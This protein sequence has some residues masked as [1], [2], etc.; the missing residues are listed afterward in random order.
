MIPL[1]WCPPKVGAN[2]QTD[3]R[4]DTATEWYG[5]SG[6]VP[7]TGTIDKILL[8]MRTGDLVGTSPTFR[9]AIETS[10]WASNYQVPSGTD[11]ATN[12][13]AT[14]TVAADTINEYALTANASVTVG[15]WIGITIRHS[16][17][18]INGSNYIDIATWNAFSQ[19]RTG[20]YSPL[21]V[22]YTG[23]YAPSTN[24]P[25]I[26][27]L[28]DDGTPVFPMP[29]ISDY[30]TYNGR[31]ANYEYGNR[32]RLDRHAL[33]KGAIMDL[34][35]INLGSVG[36][37]MTISLYNGSGI[38]LASKVFPYPS[39]YQNTQ[40]NHWIEWDA[41][42]RINANEWHRLVT[43]G[44]TGANNWRSDQFWWHTNGYDYVWGTYPEQRFWD[45][46]ATE[47]AYNASWNE[48]DWTQNTLKEEAIQPILCAIEEH[49]VIVRP[50]RLM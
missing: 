21:P 24:L 50:R 48:G 30:A 47:R 39:L 14:G 13:Y 9:F 17:G 35:A 26:T 25:A 22:H 11:W 41:P 3:Y 38:L 23:T 40:F 42:V 34:R 16:S 4:L 8:S 29:G 44:N 28:Y 19:P 20:A 32:F 27:A 18:T 10:V 31:T 37:A 2:A 33:C 43:M 46:H 36:E 45:H 1:L 15:D 49:P 12:T 6:P 7:K 5:V